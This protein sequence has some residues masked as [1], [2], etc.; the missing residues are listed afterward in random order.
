VAQ[1]TTITGSIGIFGLMF[2]MQGFLND[3]LGITN[4]VVNTGKYSDIMT[5]TRPLSEYEKTVIQS[6]V[7]DGYQTFITKVSEARN[8]PLEKVKSVAGGRVWSGEQAKEKG[9]VDVLG[10]FEDAVEIAAEAAGIGDDYRT[11]FY[12]RQR[13]FFEELLSAMSDEADARISGKVDPLFE[14]YLKDIQ[15]LERMRGI[16]VRL[17]FDIESQ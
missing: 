14:N 7:E 1:P 15:K 3:K 13:P 6:S 9:L 17:P 4:D 10:N 8:L 12:P 16:Q 11:S 2:N 5:L